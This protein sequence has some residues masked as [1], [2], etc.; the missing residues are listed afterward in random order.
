MAEQAAEIRGLGV[1]RPI[2]AAEARPAE[3]VFR[4][5]A[6]PVDVARVGRRIE[7]EQ[8]PVRSDLIGERD[9]PGEEMRQCGRIGQGR[10]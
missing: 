4:P 5:F 9:H 8:L 1:G 6:R 10:A 7:L 3:R 2:R